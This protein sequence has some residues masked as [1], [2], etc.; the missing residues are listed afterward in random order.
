MILPVFVYLCL[1]VPELVLSAQ[2][3]WALLEDV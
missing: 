3:F 1:S 2:G